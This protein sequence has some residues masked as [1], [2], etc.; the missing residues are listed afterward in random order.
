[1]RAASGRRRLS[2]RRRRVL[3]TAALL[4]AALA[5]GAAVLVRAYRQKQT[6]RYRPGEANA[7]ITQSLA[8]DL[9]P[10]APRPVF[11]DVTREA[12]LAGFVTFAGA[13]TSQLPEDMGPGVAW[14]DYDNDGDD[15]VFLVSAGGP[16]GAPADRLAPSALYENLGDGRFRRVAGFPE[17]RIHGM[18]AAWGDYDGDGWLD[19][20]VSGY[21]ALL[22]F[23]N[24]HGRFALEPRFPSRKGFWSGLA[25]GDYDNDRRL[26][27]YVCRYVKYVAPDSAHT[28]AA[29]QQYGQAVPFTLNPASY[30]PQPNLLFH[31]AGGGRLVET[32]ARLGVANPKGRSLSALWHDFD[33]DGWLDLYVAN[34]ISDNALYR[35]AGGRFTDVSDRAWVADYR[36]AM[37]LAAGDWN[38]D[39]DDDLFI[40]HWIAQ[41]NA[42]YDSLLADTGTLRFA[43]AADTVGLGQIALPMVGWGTE[44]LDFDGDGWLDL[45]VANGSTLETEDRPKRLVPQRPFLFWNRRGEHFHDVAPLAPPLAQEHVARG[46]AVA[47][48]DGDGDLDVLMASNGGGVQLLRND[49]PGGHWVEVALRARAAAD[50]P[51]T[52]AR[53]ATAVAQVGPLRLRRSVTSASYLSQ[54]TSTLCFG[55]G[56]AARVDKLAV[57]WRAGASAEYGPLAAGRRW[58]ITEG[59]PVPREIPRLGPTSRT[60]GPAPP[61]ERQRIAAFWD[62]E[63]AAMQALKVEKNPAKA[64]G[65]F[66]QALAL[67]PAHEDARYYLA[68]A[69]AAQ[70]DTDGALRQYAELNRANPRSHRSLVE[71]GRLRAA[72]GR[73]AGD[74]AAAET[75]LRRAHDL[76]PEETGALLMLG[77]IALMRRQPALAER[78]LAAV[79][80]ANARSAGALFLLGYIRWKAGDP[81]RAR[82]D[83]ERARTALGPDWKP[84]GSTAE[85]DVAVAAG[86]QSTL[87][88]RFW[89]RWDGTAKPSSA[90]AG[91]ERYLGGMPR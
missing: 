18:G 32:A 27:L 4:I 28:A 51:A 72:T 13:R 10:D 38:R 64:A 39:G 48:F 1:M 24:D 12:G 90:Y 15:D 7:D 5:I 21:D 2:R 73:N 16:L 3:A 17:P 52:I 86:P 57:R 33:D 6:S 46:L 68:T 43:D 36:G 53:G 30:E 25:W 81:V 47:D 29:S 66:E 19:L 20:A 37:G 77:E 62:R 89:E 34:D 26:D 82:G 56:A 11:T 71:W 75:A 40:T 41:E 60:P 14:G 9:P 49:T 22:L 85:G 45:I 23:H 50:A 76:N 44:F 69:L 63:R 70:G 42:L 65:L 58:E 54:S 91:L 35:N 59:D 8:S 87:L 78:R 79:A 83:L 67:D 80:Q 84:A 61:A 31:N 88:S 55:L 74:L